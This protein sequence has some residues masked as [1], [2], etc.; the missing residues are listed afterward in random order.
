MPAEYRARIEATRP[1][2]AARVKRDYGIELQE[3]PF[4]INTH[5][6]HELKKYADAQGK[7]NEFHDAALD[8]YWMHGRDVS[9]PEV[10]QELLKQVGI[11]TP[12]AEILADPAWNREVMIDQRVA[13]ENQM[14][15]VPALVFDE[16][17][18]VMGAQPL[19]VLKQ[20]VEQVNQE[21]QEKGET[22][23]S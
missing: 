19:E 5:K 2:F 18:L 7:G 4:G 8:A 1:V 6:L 10:Q 15:G 20:V 11:E 21:K 23:N 13:Y 12:V 17:Y 3:G 9:D 14:T 22:S 16:K